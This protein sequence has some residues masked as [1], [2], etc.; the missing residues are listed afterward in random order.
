ME[1]EI[2]TFGGSSKLNLAAALRPRKQGN[3]LGQH[4]SKKWA[5]PFDSS[6]S[7]EGTCA[8][9]ACF[10]VDLGFCY[11]HRSVAIDTSF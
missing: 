10:S 9:S 1:E 8:F 2:L 5:S 11:R 3:S 6:S 4:K 7:E